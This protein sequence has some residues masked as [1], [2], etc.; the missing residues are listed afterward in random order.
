MSLTLKII[1]PIA[2]V[3]AL[4][5]GIYSIRSGS[6]GTQPFDN[7]PTAEQ[8]TDTTNYQIGSKKMVDA[9]IDALIND[10]SAE[11]TGTGEEYDD[12]ALL[13]SDSEALN[14]FNTIYESSNY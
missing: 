13:N 3:I 11:P 12:S 6:L 10:A 2:I 8:A 9:E 4:A 5:L 14:N 1:L 7:Q